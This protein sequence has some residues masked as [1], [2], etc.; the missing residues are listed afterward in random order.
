MHVLCLMLRINSILKHIA[1][2]F[3]HFGASDD[4]LEKRLLDAIGDSGPDL[5]Q[6]EQ[7][8]GKS[9]LIRW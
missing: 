1:K 2:K 4:V 9:R 7:K 3:L 5:S 8:L 6:E